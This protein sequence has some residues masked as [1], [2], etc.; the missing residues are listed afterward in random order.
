MTEKMSLELDTMWHVDALLQVFPI[1]IVT[2][3]DRE[4]RINAA[5]YSLVLPFCSSS[6]NPQMLLISNKNWHTAKNI[7]ATGEFVLNYPRAG[8]LK[9]VTETSYFHPAGV[10]EL[11][12]TGYTTI[13][14]RI[15]RPPRIAECY[16][17]VE[18]RV[19]GIIR[20]SLQQVNIIADV[21]DI[22]T[23][24]GLCELSRLERVQAVNAP[25][26]LGVDEERGHIFGNV[27]GVVPEFLEQCAASEKKLPAHE[28]AC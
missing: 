27:S 6:K 28:A 26:Y 19:R 25:V 15:V 1:T 2:T 5:P 12:Y 8:Q 10:N 3:I 22:S 14:S 20:P 18:C 24:A 7:E 17:H 16:Q 11:D 21:L 4:G 23:D 13:P 9:E